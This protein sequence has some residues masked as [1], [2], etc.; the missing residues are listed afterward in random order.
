MEK[1]SNYNWLISTHI[2]I[3]WYEMKKA[4]KKM[5][6]N[7]QSN[8]KNNTNS[9]ESNNSRNNCADCKNNNSNRNS[10]NSNNR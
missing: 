1:N 3:G 6:N 4:D 2:N 5:N 10:S 8:I 7:A 9:Y